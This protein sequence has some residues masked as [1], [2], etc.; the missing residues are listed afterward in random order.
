MAMAP[1]RTCPHPKCGK[2]NCQ[3][4]VRPAWRSR[5]RPLVPRIRGRALQLLRARL[6]ARSPWCVECLK[7]GKHTRPT[8][9]DHVIPL[10]EGG[11]DD[12]SNEQALCGDCSDRK[13]AEEAQRGMN[14]SRFDR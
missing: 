7:Q 6:F 14:R 1:P 12:A 3:V 9:R 10:A 4:H 2:P 5:T 8:I 13:T 11:R